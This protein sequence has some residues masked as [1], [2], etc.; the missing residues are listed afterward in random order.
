MISDY[1]IRD[2][3]PLYLNEGAS[4][5]ELELKK[6][7]AIASLVSKDDKE[8]IAR[9]VRLLRAGIQG[10]Q[11]IVFELRNSHYPLVFI[12]DLCLEYEGTTAQI[13]F[14]VVSPVNTYVI[15]CKNLVGDIE[16]DG[17]GSFIRTFGRGRYRKREGIYSPITQNKRHVELIKAILR[18]ELGKVMRFA[19]QFILDD[20][21]H[22]V[23][24]LANEKSLLFADDAPREIR[25]QVIRADRLIEHIKQVDKAYARKNGRDTFKQVRRRAKNWLKRGKP[26]QSG[27][28]SKYQIV[29]SV[30]H[31]QVQ[32]P[33]KSSVSSVQVKHTG[34]T[35][36]LE[37]PACP[38]CG[39]P[40]VVRTARYGK[41]KGNRFWGCSNYGK[42]GCKGI[43]NM[44]GNSQ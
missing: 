17:S 23:V 15:E 19:Q 33:S 8:R 10:E 32:T 43:V 16:I 18:S 1:L 4:R 7:E 34:A 35:G 20:C 25:D 37:Q 2:H 41:Y 3:E 26:M 5:S 24:V 21:Y 44:E 36:S 12:H 9:D 28:A 6:L 30:P 38:L 29:E 11:R 27:V 22:S 14:L 31:A 39:A 40:M 13:D 42:N